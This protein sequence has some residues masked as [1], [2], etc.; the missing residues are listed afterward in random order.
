MSTATET[1]QPTWRC[2]ATTV[3]R[4]ERLSPGFL[5]LTFT[6]PTCTCSAPGRRPAVQAAH[7][8]RRRGRR[9]PHDGRR[10]R[11]VR[12]LV[13]AARRD[14]AGDAH[15]HRARGPARGRRARRRRGAARH[16]ARRQRR[17]RRRPRRA[18]GR[19]RVPGDPMVLLG[20]DR[21]G[22]GRMW[23]VEWAPPAGADTLLLAGDET[24][25]P[26]IASILESLPSGRGWSRC[27]R[28][29]RRRTSCPCGCRPG[30]TSGGWP[31]GPAP[32]ASCS[33]PPC[34]PRCASSASPATSPA[35]TRAS[36]SPTASSGRCPR[37]A[38]TPAATPGWPARRA[39]SRACA[40]GWCAT[41]ASPRRGGVHGLLEGRVPR[42]SRWSRAR[43]WSTSPTSSAPGPTAGGGTA[44]G[45]P[46]AC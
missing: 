35:P 25:V 22:S 30:S 44:P 18:V 8:G 45:R 21:P 5:R 37:P 34:T 11:L 27:S 32:G 33:S 14:P 12:G 39:W 42:L 23:G 28:C 7:P 4:T 10:G 43:C 3:A 46:A 15:L 36:R 6:A 24:A 19:P 1:L 20:P 9:R 40:A 38:R 29:P 13:R 31:A 26:A 16:P 17:A 41:S 2:F